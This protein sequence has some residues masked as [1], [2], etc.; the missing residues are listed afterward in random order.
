MKRRIIQIML[1]MLLALYSH[2]Q[3]YISLLDGSH[4]SKINKN[5]SI[6]DVK[7]LDDGV[8]VTYNFA[9]VSAI[10]D[11]LY[12]G[13][14]TLKINGFGMNSNAGEP[15]IPKRVDSFAVPDNATAEVVIE[16]SNYIDLPIQLS[17]A[18]PILSESKNENYS[19]R[20]VPNI[21]PFSSNLNE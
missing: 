15:F 11:P 6:R 19:K 16:T 20:N 21:K 3:T 12:S 1:F 10:E 13:K 2:A 18:R 9:F 5:E 4:V 7:I 14:T 17:P 8:S